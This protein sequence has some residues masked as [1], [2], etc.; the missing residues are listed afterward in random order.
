MYWSELGEDALQVEDVDWLLRFGFHSVSPIKRHVPEMEAVLTTG[1]LTGRSDRKIL[2][3][4]RSHPS[5]LA[6][7]YAPS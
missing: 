6:A 5:E 2:S 7:S 4:P 3:A 1:A